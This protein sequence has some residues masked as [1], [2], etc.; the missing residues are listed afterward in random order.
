MEQQIQCPE[1]HTWNSNDKSFCEKC[2]ARLH[3]FAGEWWKTYNMTPVRL[4]QLKVDYVGTIILLFLF[5]PIIGMSIV[6][7]VVGFMNGFLNSYVNEY[8]RLPMWLGLIIFVISLTVLILTILY[9]KK[10]V[11]EVSYP[12]ACRVLRKELLDD[13]YIEIYKSRKVHYVFIARGNGNSH[14][15]GLFDV[16]KIKICIPM[17]YDELK[18]S[19]KGKLL[20]GVLNGYPVIIDVNGNNYQ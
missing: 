16:D 18:W 12:N 17:K 9:T 7:S 15:F 3:P 14:K 20:K 19:E 5:V 4:F 11:L 6:F 10:K 8:D 1:C 13:D 2:G